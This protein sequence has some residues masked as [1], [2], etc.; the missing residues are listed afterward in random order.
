MVY[1][2]IRL[3]F[4]KSKFKFNYLC[5]ILLYLRACMSFYKYISF[6]LLTFYSLSLEPNNH[7]INLIFHSFSTHFHSYN[8]LFSYFLSF[9]F[10][11]SS[12]QNL[13]YLFGGLKN[14]KSWRMY[15]KSNI[16][17]AKINVNFII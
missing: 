17:K 16:F 11:F 9:H 15:E 10:F 8:I 7:K 14:L 2:H 4:I 1:I 5:Y 13:M 3:Y 12:K 6:F